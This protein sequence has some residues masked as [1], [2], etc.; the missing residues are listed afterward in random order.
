[1]KKSLKN[2]TRLFTIALILAIPQTSHAMETVFED[3]P[4]E[5]RSLIVKQAAY[6]QCLEEKNPVSLN[7]TL[8]NLALV[9]KEWK[10]IINDDM[11]VGKLSW[12]AWNGVTP[13]NENIYQQF[14]NGI[15]IYR[16]DPK[17]DKGKIELPIAALTNPLESTFDLSSCGD[18]GKHLSIA[19][20]YSKGYNPAN[21]TKVEVWLTPRFLVDQNMSTLP[22]NHC[23]RKIIEEG[24]WDT[25]KAPVGI[26]WTSRGCWLDKTLTHCDYITNQSMEDLGDGSLNKKW[27]LIQYPIGYMSDN[28]ND[29]QLPA[30]F[31][32][33]FHVSF[34]K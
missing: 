34:V 20:G 17:S 33:M 5:L 15:L 3:I 30:Y 31:L 18:T 24:R 6:E 12:K 16:P 4:E 9:C 7:K 28:P 32:K 8:V 1:M 13:K 22:H 2:I 29:Y 27:N 11:Q 10:G 14:L 19:T 23:L 26:F 25:A 21:S